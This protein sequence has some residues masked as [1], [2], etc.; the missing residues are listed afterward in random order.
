MYLFYFFHFLFI[1]LIIRI[2][3]SANASTNNGK[4][5]LAWVEGNW[6]EVADFVISGSAKG[7]VNAI[8]AG[9]MW[10]VSSINGSLTVNQ[11]R[12]EEHKKIW[13]GE[14]AKLAKLRT[15]P[16]IGFGGNITVLRQLFLEKDQFIA[17]VCEQI[18]STA[19]DG[20]NIDFEPL[21]NVHNKHD[22][23]APTVE[24]GAAF[25]QFLDQLSKA[26]HQLPG[27]KTVQM[28]SES[29]VGACWSKPPVPSHAW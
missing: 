26:V 27:S 22:P 28:D 12:V 3:S 25:A 11:A 16:V 8:S 18:S 7:A 19:V 5:V 20:V 13:Q 2:T 17:D 24:D 9:G 1:F 4:T 29:I 23:N 6:T 14:K 10:G 21:S 15:Y